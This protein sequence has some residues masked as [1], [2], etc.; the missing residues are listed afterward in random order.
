[1]NQSSNILKNRFGNNRDKVKTQIQFSRER[2]S[3]YL[4]RWFHLKGILHSYS[5]DQM[6]SFPIIKI[7]S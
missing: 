1:M 6:K 5:Q 4:K 3:E 2:E 7:T